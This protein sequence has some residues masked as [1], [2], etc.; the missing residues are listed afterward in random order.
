MRDLIVST[1]DAKYVR[2]AGQDTYPQSAG[3]DSLTIIDAST[4]PPKVARR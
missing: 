1:N 4:Y 3:S 2:V